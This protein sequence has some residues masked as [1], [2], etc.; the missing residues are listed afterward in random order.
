MENNCSIIDLN[1]SM[2]NSKELVNFNCGIEQLNN[3]IINDAIN[4][5]AHYQTNTELFID[6]NISEKVING[7]CTNSVGSLRLT[8]N[9]D[10]DKYKLLSPINDEETI[11]GSHKDFILPVLNLMYLGVDKCAQQKHIGTTLILN[12][13][14]DL[15]WSYTKNH[16]GISGI[17]LEA[18]PSASDFYEMFGFDYLC[19]ADKWDYKPNIYPMFIPITKIT[20]I[21]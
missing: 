15:F 1:S 2:V 9:S 3:F 5:D 18:L 17:Y 7:F 21:L 10:K 13:F 19:D 14:K 6:K 16:L 11:N 8:T 4:S 12:L 20:D